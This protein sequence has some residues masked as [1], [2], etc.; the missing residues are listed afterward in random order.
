MK[1]WIITILVI[2]LLLVMALAIFSDKKVNEGDRM[3][4]VSSLL[5]GPNAVYVSDQPSGGSVVV[6]QSVFENGGYIVVHEDASGAPGAIVGNSEY[7][8][9][10]GHSDVKIS[11][12]RSVEN[13]ERLYAMLHTDN[14]DQEFDPQEDEP[15]TDE[16]DNV[17]FMKFQVDDEAELPKDISV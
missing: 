6:T 7:L 15:I 14:G 9:S 17:I 4:T 10:G 13:G 5:A 2:I 3:G 1:K 12:S 16:N 8:K 11:V